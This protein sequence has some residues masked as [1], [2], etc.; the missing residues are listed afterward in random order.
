MKLYDELIEKMNIKEG[1]DI[2]IAS[3]IQ[4]IGLKFYEM[5]KIFDLNI[6]INKLQ[7]KITNNGTIVFPTYNWEFCKGITFDY[8]KTKSKTGALSQKALKRKEFSRTKHPIYSFAVWGKDKEILCSMTNRTSFGN[9][10]PFTY[11]KEKNYKM[12][13]LDVS[14]TNSLTFAHHMEEILN[15]PYRFSKDFTAKYIDDNNKEELR[16]YSMFVRYL[17]FDV[18]HNM[19][20]LEK[21]AEEKGILKENKFYEISIKN[22]KLKELSELIKKDILF[23]NSLNIAQY[24]INK[25]K[26]QKL[27][28]KL[29]PIC[30]SITGN[31]LRESLS[32]I[33]KEVPLNIIEIPT[34]TKAFDWE[35]PREWNI[36]DAYVKGKDGNRI[37]D[38]NKSNLHVL[39]YSIPIREKLSKEKLLEHI[40]TLPDLP[41]A[42]PY[43]TSYYKE[44]WG[45]C[46]EHNRLSELKDEEYEVCI[47]SELKNGSMSI[48]EG[49]I[50]GKSKKEVLLS[51]YLCHPSMGNNELSGPIVQTLLYN[52]LL[53][54]KENLKY[55]YRFL[56]LPETI[57]SITYLSLKGKELKENVIAGYVIT[58]IGDNGKFTYKKS[59]KGDTLADRAALNILNNL[60]EGYNL[61]EWFPGGSDERQY[62]S[63]EFNLPVGSLMRTM[64]GKYKEYHTSLDNFEFIPVEKLYE[65]FKTYKK[66]I[67]NIEINETFEA[68]HKNCEPKLDKRGLYPTLGSQ[69]ET[70]ES[71]EKIMNLWAFSDGKN[72]LIDIANR[73]KKNAYDFKREKEELLKNNLIKIIESDTNE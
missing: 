53:E 32:I 3:D 9:D 11:F 50:E 57:G 72:D 59:K 40:Y 42:I 4:R 27:K 5:E 21:I 2:F 46:L 24:D 36:K 43:L 1:E 69:K 22:T 15:A 38:F 73:L 49:Y 12:I 30:R 47:D 19:D 66:I 51:T 29:F 62:C 26:I 7:E 39:G 54:N 23:N 28:E 31:G 34:G 60:E 8:K 20:K 68:V 58:C 6:F 48:G 52:W 18:G 61:Y 70:T 56:Y 33:N 67:M 64:Y 10:S 45:F 13:F 17:E 37:I 16:T 71:V 44:R 35:V 41:N 14:F 25:L 65:S 55:S 63:H